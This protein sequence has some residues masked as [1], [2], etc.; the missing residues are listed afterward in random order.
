MMKLV[1]SEPAIKHSVIALSLLHQRYDQFDACKTENTQDAIKQHQIALSSARV[2]LENAQHDDVPKVLLLCI[3]FV[4]Y[5][6]VTGQYAAAQTHLASGLK[7]LHQH[8]QKLEPD[9]SIAKSIH[10]TRDSNIEALAEYFSRLD[11]QAMTFSDNRAPYDY[12]S[13]PLRT[14]GRISAPL[15]PGRFVTINDASIVLMDLARKFMYLTDLLEKGAIPPTEFFQTLATFPQAVDDWNSAFLALKLIGIDEE[16]RP[17]IAILEIYHVLLKLLVIFD[18]Q[19]IESSWDI[20]LPSFTLIV[21]IAFAFMEMDAALSDQTTGIAFSFN[22]GITIPLFITAIK[23]RDPSIRREAIRLLR[24]K[25]RVEGVWD[26]LGAAAV[27]ERLMHLEEQSSTL[28]SNA[29]DIP[30]MARVHSTMIAA[31]TEKRMVTATFLRRS[32]GLDEPWVRTECV[33]TY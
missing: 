8:Q 33:I 15:I 21:E 30:E 7:I 6:N 5:A 11:F 1:H 28:V 26:S 20:F 16:A 14:S 31:E 10:T 23:C 2:L 3:L 32:G 25:R 22:L 9:F 17:S 18:Y 13:F 19:G 24:V 12:A 4:C 29:V 27:A